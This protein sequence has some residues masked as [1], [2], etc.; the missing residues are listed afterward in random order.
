M[1][2]F[3]PWLDDLGYSVKESSLTRDQLYIAD[4]VFICGTAA[5]LVAVR[6]IDFRQVGGGKPGQVT[7]HLQEAYHTMLHGEGPHAAAWLDFVA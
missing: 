7:R 6:M 5:E 4:E 1:I 2:R 3:L